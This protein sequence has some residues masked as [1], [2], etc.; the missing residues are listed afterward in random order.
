MATTWHQ[1]ITVK[2]LHNKPVEVHPSESQEQGDKML[3][4]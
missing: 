3:Q 4:M 1:T 2:L